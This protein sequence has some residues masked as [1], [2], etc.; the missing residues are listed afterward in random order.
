MVSYKCSR[1]GKIFNHKGDFTRHK[2]RKNPCK[3]KNKISK[4]PKN[5]KSNPKQFHRPSCPEC[6]KRYSSSSNLNK[7]IRRSCPVL[8]NKVKMVNFGSGLKDDLDI[9]DLI[10]SDNNSIYEYHFSEDIS[11][12]RTQNEHKHELNEHKVISKSKI[13]R[14]CA[15][16]FT[17]KTSMYRHIRKYCKEKKTT[18]QKR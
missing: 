14:Y 11:D 15:K 18:R 10:C 6:G 7:H 13:C 5:P 8:K 1:C 3:I 9:D 17:T 12:K 4:N 2:N 16:E